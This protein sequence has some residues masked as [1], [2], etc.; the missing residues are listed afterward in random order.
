LFQFGKSDTLRDFVFVDDIGNYIVQNIIDENI[1][2]GTF[3]LTSGK[4]TSMHEVIKIAEKSLNKKIYFSFVDATNAS[5]MSFDRSVFP[6]NWS[7]TSNAV[8]IKK[9]LLKVQCELL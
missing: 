9:T 1:A 3:F 6:V 8:G 5:H 2:S 4:T 7:P